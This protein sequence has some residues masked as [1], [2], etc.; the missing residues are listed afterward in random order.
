MSNQVAD[1]FLISP[2]LMSQSLQFFNH[3]VVNVSDSVEI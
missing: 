1:L 2:V 3:F